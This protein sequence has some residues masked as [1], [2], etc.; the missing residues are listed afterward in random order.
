MYEEYKS[1][2]LSVKM[3]RNEEMDNI[4]SGNIGEFY[5]YAYN[6]HGG[7]SPLTVQPLKVCTNNNELTSN[8]LEQADLFNKYFVSVFTVDNGC[9]PVIQPR[10]V[11]NTFCDTML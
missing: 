5:R 9:K 3:P 8:S 10:I 11:E 1:T 6:K 4:S 7:P 2:V